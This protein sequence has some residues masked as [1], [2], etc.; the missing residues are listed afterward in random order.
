MDVEEKGGGY[1]ETR[2]STPIHRHP[3]LSAATSDPITPA[4]V[5]SRRDQ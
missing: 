2:C 3:D 5:L 4:R 1:G